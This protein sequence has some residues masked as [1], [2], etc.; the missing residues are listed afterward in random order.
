MENHI[1]FINIIA[2][3]LL[4]YAPKIYSA[5][6]KRII[7]LSVDNNRHGFMYDY[8]LAKFILTEGR[9]DLDLNFIFVLEENASCKGSYGLKSA[10]SSK[11]IRFSPCIQNKSPVLEDKPTCYKIDEEGNKLRNLN[12]QP[13][14]FKKEQNYNLC[15]FGID[16][17]LV[18]K[19]DVFEIKK[20]N[21][22]YN[23][24]LK[25]VETFQKLS[26]KQL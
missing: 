11:F 18:S 5:N 9:L 4:I 25:H 19:V 26:L 16:D 21:K 10:T 14:F 2:L 15:I 20:T 7:Y 17:F 1:K 6:E 12:N 23:K 3:L 24:I 22:K 13:V 8:H